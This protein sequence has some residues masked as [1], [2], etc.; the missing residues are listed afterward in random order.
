MRALLDPKGIAVVGASP[1]PGPGS[2]VLANLRDAGFR[3]SVF[4]VNPRYPEVLGYPCVANVGALPKEVD[5]LVVAVA[6]ETACGVLEAAQAHGIPAAV[7][8]SAGFGEGGRHDVRSR[9]LRA[10]ADRGMAICGPNCFGLINVR[11]GAAAFSGVVPKAMAPGGVALISQSGSLGNFVFGPLVRDRK[12]GFSH[13]ISCGNQVGVTVEDYVDSLVDDPEVQVIACIIEA[14]KQPDKLSRAALRAHAAR[15]SLVVFHAG[16]SAAGREMVRSHTGALAGEADILRAFLRRCGI[17]QADSYDQFVETVALFAIAPF[18]PA[19]GEEVVLVSGSGGA[20]AVAAD[21]LEAAGLR[22]AVLDAPTSERLREVLPEFASPTNPV[23]AT[24]VVYDDPAL[25]PALFEAILAQPGR[26]IVAS[27]VNIVA[28][29]RLRRIAGVIAEAA[30]HS[31]RT[32]VAYQSSPLG[33]LDE[34]IVRTLHAAKVPVLLGIQNAMGALARLKERRDYALRLTAETADTAAPARRASAGSPGAD[35]P[36]DFLGL[37][38]LLVAAGVPVV[39]AMLATTAAEAVTI[40][41]RFGGPVALKAEAAGL[42]HKSDIGAVSLDR[43]SEADV[44]A[45]FEAVSVNAR[46]AG[47][48]PAGVLVQPMVT[49]VAEC[50]AG[51]KAD[52]LYGP[53]IVFGLGGLFVEVLRESATELAPLTTEEAL[54]MI[55]RVKGASILAGARGRPPGDVAALAQCLVHLSRFAQAHAGSFRALDLNPIVVM[56]RGV[57]AVDIAI[58]VA[59]DLV[60]A[61]GSG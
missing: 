56:P 10:L 14:L 20:A 57:V 50:F 30:R 45:G 29:D 54:R 21:S 49:G 38:S 40:W 48:A 25:M 5:C 8:L 9:R 2:R 15:K 36:S 22:L 12:L 53:A 47:F 33:P 28:A 11:S 37:R 19:L 23:D 16:T 13:F 1:R 43:R 61:P 18:D 17:V 46:K 59:T 24:G 27:T 51:I 35:I 55:R 39:D 3:G 44:I 31:G 34:E 58:E 4:A 6:A 7:V 42:I 32:I 26:P 60:A 41:R 52:P